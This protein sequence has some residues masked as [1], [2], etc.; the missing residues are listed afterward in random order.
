ME[1]NNLFSYI[2]CSMANI[3]QIEIGVP[4]KEINLALYNG[5]HKTV[6]D[7]HKLPSPHQAM[8]YS[9]NNNCKKL[10]MYGTMM[11]MIMCMWEVPKSILYNF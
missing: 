7:S 11:A 4:K 1:N 9:V 2:I 6:W 8:G 10:I 3:Q 5:Q